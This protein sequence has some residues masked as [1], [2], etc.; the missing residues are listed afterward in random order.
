MSRDWTRDELVVAMNVYGRLAFGQ[1]HARTPLVQEVAARLGRTPGALAMKLCNLASLDPQI[2]ASGR[3]GLR[4]A[5]RLDRE[6]WGA[7]H[8]DWTQLAAES[9]ARFETLM[10]GSRFVP[11]EDESTADEADTVREGPTEAA[12]TGTRRL[13]QHF[14]RRVVL[15][16][17]GE[18]CC[19]TGT[20]LPELL[21]ASHIVRWADDAR[22]RL[23]PRNGL[24]LA[25]TQ[26]AAFDRH[27]ITLD[28]DLRL[29]VSRSIRDHYTCESIRLNFHPYEGK[30]IT[31]PHRFA[32]DP[33]LL[34]RHREAFRG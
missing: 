2:T 28:E 5:S 24:C 17:Y 20:P 32:P 16:S 12:V 10:R 1:L 34:A 14:F 26:D 15:V 33:A 13:G 18:R 7:F 31:R 19:I 25:R 21:T 22:E 30:P 4:G 6:V 11:R 27:L 3:V 8:A 9:E 29:V 23:N